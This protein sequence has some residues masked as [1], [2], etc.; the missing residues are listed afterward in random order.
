MRPG[1]EIFIFGHFRFFPVFFRFFRFFFCFG[2]PGPPGLV[3]S[4]VFH[5]FF[6]DF[7]WFSWFWWFWIFI[8]SKLGFNELFFFALR[9]H[10]LFVNRFSLKSLLQVIVDLI[11]S[12][13]HVFFNNIDENLVIDEIMS[14]SCPYVRAGGGASWPLLKLKMYEKAI[15]SGNPCFFKSRS[16]SSSPSNVK[17]KNLVV[18]TNGVVPKP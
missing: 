16:S 4:M 15:I 10:V 17:W 7:W 13:K 3:C 18:G 11:W 6:V 12:W 2:P 9:H 8:A 5:C 1:G 14:K